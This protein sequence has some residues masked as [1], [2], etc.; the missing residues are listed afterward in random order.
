[1]L[2]KATIAMAVSYLFSA[3]LYAVY[4]LLL[5]HNK[6]KTPPYISFPLAFLFLT[7]LPI[8][9]IVLEYRRGR[10]DLFVSNINLRPKFFIPAII[11]YTVGAIIFILLNDKVMAVYFLCYLAVTA[12]IFLIS[13]RWKISI[14]TAG[15]AGPTTFLAHYFSPLYTLLYLLVPLIAWSRYKLKA[16]TIPQLITGAL[17]ALVVTQ[18][19]CYISQPILNSIK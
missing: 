9:Y 10:T 3:P 16:H 7:F 5:I 14:H 11:S 19:M 2:R 1:M 4:C 18:A 6:I 12:T 13:L 15:I 8:A 17:V